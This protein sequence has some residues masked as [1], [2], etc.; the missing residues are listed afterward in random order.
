VEGG[1][2][3]VFDTGKRPTLTIDI[4]YAD[5]T[6]VARDGSQV[7]ASASKASDFG[8]FR[9]KAPFTALQDG[10]A[11][12]ITTP[13]RNTWGS[14]DDRMVT[15]VVPP[16]TAVTVLSAGDITATGLRADASIKSAGSGS[17]T[18]EDYKAP[19]LRVASRD[20][21]TLSQ[22]VADR[23]DASSKDGHVEG[24]DVRVRDGNVTSDEHVT[25]GFAPGSDALISAE[26]ND[27]KVHVSGF[28][29]GS[30]AAETTSSD[31]DDASTRTVRVGA[32]AG[33]FSVHAND[34]SITLMQDG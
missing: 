5:L 29:A 32:G 7:D 26:T 23:L 3:K 14:G 12:H 6:I 2:H 28:P 22:V 11:I 16:E 21:I 20:S 15:V 9:S 24:T 31:D 1:S 17:I 10:D 18:I 33:H 13:G 8:L 30:A 27:G 25:L 4:G 19:T 34:G